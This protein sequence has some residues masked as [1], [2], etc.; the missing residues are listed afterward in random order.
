M[1]ITIQTKHPNLL[2]HYARITLRS[3]GR[4]AE[5][6]DLLTLGHFDGEQL[7]YTQLSVAQY[8]A[9]EDAAARL[10]VPYDATQ[11]AS[12]RALLRLHL[13]EEAGR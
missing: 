12:D 10:G 7:T 6:D 4:G 3:R 8:I 9:L 5:C 13:D 2:I 11:P 1:N